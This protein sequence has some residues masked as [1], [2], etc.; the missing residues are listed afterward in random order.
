MELHLDPF[1]CIDQCKAEA[2]V[3][4]WGLR[5]AAVMGSWLL[6]PRA[7]S[8]PLHTQHLPALQHNARLCSSG[9]R[10]RNLH[11]PLSLWGGELHYFGDYK[12]FSHRQS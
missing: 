7:S 5:A 12:D 8:T 6:A 2:S 4:I 9:G 11:G 1:F 3:S 10:D